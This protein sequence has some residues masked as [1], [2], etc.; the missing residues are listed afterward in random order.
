MREKL[1]GLIVF[2]VLAIGIFIS[3]ICELFEKED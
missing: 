2:T 3:G 1:T